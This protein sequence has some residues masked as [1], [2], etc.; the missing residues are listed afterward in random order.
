MRI[1]VPTTELDMFY[2][3]IVH[4]FEEMDEQISETM[5]M[6]VQQVIRGLVVKEHGLRILPQAV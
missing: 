6:E 3:R 4:Q 1:K 2:T 5:L